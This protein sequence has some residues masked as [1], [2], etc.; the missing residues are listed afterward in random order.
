MKKLKLLWL[1]LLLSIV[2]KA[3]VT[4]DNP[5]GG[6]N[7]NPGDIIVIEWHVTQTHPQNNW[8]L[9]YSTDGGKSWLDLAVDLSISQMSYAWTTPDIETAQ[10]KI[11]IVMDNVGTN[12][13][14]A[15][16]V[17]GIGT[18][19]ITAID[20]NHLSNPVN[21]FPNPFSFEAKFQVQLNSLSDI[22]LQIFNQT[23][24]QVYNA[25]FYEQDQGMTSLRWQPAALPSGIYYYKIDTES[26]SISGKIILNR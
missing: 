16:G 18:G 4:L 24:R 11:K 8:D 23:G 12:Y 5:S 3:H 22:S 10:A 2:V 15:S 6:E 21:V 26:K 14:D 1:L 9:Y 7:V 17:F 13:E 20:E 19:V 25:L